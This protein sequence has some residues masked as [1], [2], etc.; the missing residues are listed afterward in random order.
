M[1]AIASMFD[2]IVLLHK[3]ASSRMRKDKQYADTIE[4]VNSAFAKIKEGGYWS[5]Y[6]EEAGE[7][8]AEKTC[9]E[10]VSSC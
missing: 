10:P 8:E 3:Y 7:N 1:F 9:Q 6:E 5:E 2:M 4:H